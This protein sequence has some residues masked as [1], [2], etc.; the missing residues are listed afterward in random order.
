[1]FTDSMN[2]MHE[3]K[4]KAIKINEDIEFFNPI[5][6]TKKE[7]LSPSC[8]SE[9]YRKRFAIKNGIISFI[10]ETLNWYVIPELKGIRDCLK[11]AGYIQAGFYVPCSDGHSYPVKDKKKWE[12]LIQQR[13]FGF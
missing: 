1:M 10:D 12:L 8:F 13:N 7:T 6:P 3:L 5:P 4:N 2:P 9:T 11:K